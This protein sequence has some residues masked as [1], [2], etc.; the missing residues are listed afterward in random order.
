VHELT[1][2]RNLLRI[3]ERSAAAEGFAR[4]HSVTLAIGHLSCVDDGALRFG[5][6]VLSRGTLAEGAVLEIDRVPGRA[7]CGACGT[8]AAVLTH[9]DVC[10]VCGGPL[11]AVTGGDEM[12]I[13]HV[14]VE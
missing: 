14:E 2:C 5:F 6:D 10:A 4:V 13:R 8:P 9:L 12:L 11:Q 1:L 3:L 7:R